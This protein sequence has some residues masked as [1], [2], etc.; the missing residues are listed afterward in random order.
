MPH[1]KGKSIRY[2]RTNERKSAGPGLAYIA[3]YS[4]VHFPE[5]MFIVSLNKFVSFLNSNNL[6][7]T[8]SVKRTLFYLP[9]SSASLTV[10]GRTFPF[11]SGRSNDIRP[12][13]TDKLPNMIRG[14][15]V[16]KVPSTNFPYKNG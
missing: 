9:N 13:K 3:I 4:F 12:A 11:V 7:S 2:N 15:A 8:M 6:I 16:P 10:S 5:D 14:K 1:K